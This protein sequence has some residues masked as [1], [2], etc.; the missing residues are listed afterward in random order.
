M[1]ELNKLPLK[2]KPMIILII[3][4][5]LFTHGFNI[6]Y[7]SNIRIPELTIHQCF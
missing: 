7:S 3:G 1:G 5:I 4:Q 2:W 6:L